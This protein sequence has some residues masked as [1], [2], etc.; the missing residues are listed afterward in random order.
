[1][2][3]Q[4]WSRGLN[5]VLAEATGSNGRYFRS[6]TATSL[7]GRWTPPAVAEG[8]PLAGMANSGATWTNDIS[9]RD[10][11]SLSGGF[12]CL[13]DGSGS[14]GSSPAASP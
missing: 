6:C 12:R 13:L 5:L 4:L 10:P 14:C 3:Y 9:H 8:N 2:S 7:G 1:M 11:A